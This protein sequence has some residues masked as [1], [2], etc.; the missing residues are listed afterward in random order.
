MVALAAA[1]EAIEKFE[2]TQGDPAGLGGR[3]LFLVG[4][5]LVE[6]GVLNYVEPAD[7][8][9]RWPSFGSEVLPDDPGAMIRL[10]GVS[11]L[12]AWPPR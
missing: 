11:D 6:V 4:G 7:T 12:Y 2:R 5:L 9:K 1:F 8:K 3:F 10:I